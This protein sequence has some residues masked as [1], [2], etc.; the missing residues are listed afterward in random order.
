VTSSRH[1]LEPGREESL[2]GKPVDDALGVRRGSVGVTLKD[3]ARVAGVHPATVSRALDPGKMWLVRRETRAKV[4][5]VA[6]ELGYRGDVVARSLRRGQ[7][8]TLGVIVADLGNSFLAP[9]LRGI[10]GELEKHGFM[11]LISETQD[12]HA[13]LRASIENLLSRRVDGF[14]VTTARLGDTPVIEAVARDAPVV[15]AVRSLPGSA[16]PS[17]TSDDV[18]GAYMAAR[19]L[20]ELGHELFAELPGPSNVQ[21]FA[22]RTVGFAQA[23]NALGVGLVPVVERAIHPTPSEGGRLME[24]LLAQPGPRPT[25]VF[26]HS[27]AMAIG[28]IAAAR[29]AGLRCPKD[30]SIIGYNDAPLVDHLDPPLTTIRFP[31]DQIGRFAADLAIALVEEPPPVVASMS[32]PPEL[33]IRSS[34]GPPPLRPKGTAGRKRPRR[35]ASEE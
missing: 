14:I 30:V 23:A 18:A 35:K 10:A 21:P 26:A 34:T 1:R 8:T 13:R 6:K 33:V 28:A 19:H 32:F 4:Q 20:A 5:S 15:L 9:V 7:T 17:V 2:D 16:L 11:A 3:V 22:D 31:G 25:A 27:D 24:A 29:N 12:D